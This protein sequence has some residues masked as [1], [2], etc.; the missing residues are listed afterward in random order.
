MAKRYMSKEER[1]FYAV[2]QAFSYFLAAR[3]DGLSDKHGNIKEVRQKLRS[4]RTLTEKAAALLLQPLDIAD[5][6]RAKEE[7]GKMRVVTRYSDQAL[8]AYKEVLALD[9]YTPMLTDHFLSLVSHS[10]IGTCQ[11]CKK[12]GTEADS[13]EMKQIFIAYDVQPYDL[14][15]PVGKCP[16]QY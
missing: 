11:V 12:A 5:Q 9:S 16:Y 8:A 10:L 3:V 1:D 15:A 2:L 6:E 14:E 4:A 7:G 13:C